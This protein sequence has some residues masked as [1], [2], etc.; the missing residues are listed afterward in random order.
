[1]DFEYYQ[2]SSKAAEILNEAR[3][4]RCLTAV[5]TTAVRTLE[6][7]FKDT[8]TVASCE[9]TTD[10]FIYPGHKFNAGID[11]LITN[12]HFPKSTLVMLVSA[13]A[14]KERLFK[15]Y[16]V[17]KQNKYR[18]FSFGDSMLILQPAAGMDKNIR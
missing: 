16:E 17:A 13:F 3:C 8:E 5:G 6:T 11:R 1:M 14:G 12:F 18:F 4:E 10:L 2:V 15:S 7:I 9:G